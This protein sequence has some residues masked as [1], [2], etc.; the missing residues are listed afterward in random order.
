MDKVI[1]YGLGKDYKRNSMIFDK[2]YNVVGYCDSDEK[3]FE[4]LPE[5][6]RKK[7]VTVQKL[8]T[9]AYDYLLITTATYAAEITQ[10]LVELGIDINCIKIFPYEEEYKKIWGVTPLK[11]VSYSGGLED[12]IIDEICKRIG[13]TYDEMKYIELGVMDPVCGNNTYYFYKRGASGILVEAN[14]KRIENIKKV[15]E[16]DTI[17]NRAIYEY[18]DQEVE[19]FIS[20]VPGLSSLLRD[21]IE[22][23][24]GWEN[25]PVME[26]IKVSTIHIN[27]VFAKLGTK[28]K[29]DCLSIDI[30]GYDLQAL[31]T[32]DFSVYRP[33][34][35]IAELSAGYEKMDDYYQKI[36]ELLI[37]RDYLLYANNEYN[38]IFVDKKYQSIL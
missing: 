28:D 24:P 38:G 18:G 37:D 26:K 21:H 12:I 20:K 36:V 17:I 31:S 6:K 29:C 11:G 27:D 14:P 34:I 32:L 22:G 13:I 9:I 5:D 15:R 33:K 3:K 10:Y 23:N 25:Y 8:N 35:I 1:V 4:R 7:A 2:V 30:E 19:F 16:R